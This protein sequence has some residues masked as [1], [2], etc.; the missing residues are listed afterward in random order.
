MKTEPPEDK[1]MRRRF[2]WKIPSLVELPSLERLLACRWPG[3]A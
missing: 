1:V 3:T 2:W